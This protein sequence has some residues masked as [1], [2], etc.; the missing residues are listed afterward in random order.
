MLGL[1][2]GVL[3]ILTAGGHLRPWVLLLTFAQRTLT[4]NSL[5]VTMLKVSILT[6]PPSSVLPQLL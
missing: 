2:V 5:K 6:M 1:E 4:L 3:H